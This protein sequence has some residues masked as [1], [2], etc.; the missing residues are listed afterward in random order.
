VEG[1]GLPAQEKNPAQA[2]H[3][4]GAASSGPELRGALTAMNSLASALQYVNIAAFGLLALVCLQKWRAQR[5]EAAFWAFATFGL[6]AIV[7]V[8]GEI[9]D[10]AGDPQ[11]WITKVLV[12]LIALFPYSLYR[13][14][15]SFSRP[16][17]WIELAAAGATAA[18]VVWSLALPDVPDQGEPRSASFAIFVIA[19]LVQWTALSLFVALRL[20]RAGQGQPTVVRHRMRLLAVGAIALS[21]V[22][23]LA[24][25][26]AA[27][28]SPTFEVVQGLL[29]LASMFLFF[30]GFA[31]PKALR[32]VWREPE[33][34]LLRRSVDELLVAAEPEDV[35][36]IVL[37]Q[38]AAIV[39]ARG[40]ALLD[41]D[42]RLL[43]AYGVDPHEAAERAG[44]ERFDLGQGAVVA[45]TSP[46]APL[47][48]QEEFELLR[49][50]GGFALLAYERKSQVA[51]E[52]K[53]LQE[54]DQ[55]K[56]NFI[57]LASHELRT[58]ASVI[59]GIAS[60][61]HLRGDLLEDDQI[62]HLRQTLYEQTDRMRRLVDQLLDLSR[63][64]ANGIRIEPQPLNVFS[65]VHELIGLVATEG[66]EEVTV[67]IPANLEALVDP[68]AFD[69]I[70]SNLIVNATRYGA[71][72]IEIS[73]E[74]RDR[75]FR[76]RVE[77]HGHGVPAEFVPQLFER[78]TRSTSAGATRTE[79][80]GLGLAI[81]KSYA[82]AHGGDLLY[83]DA[84]PHGARFELVLPRELNNH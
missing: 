40:V 5:G 67:S 50:L 51:R 29:T 21:I 57:A 55:L 35:T 65:R 75:H 38:M 77:D 36:R 8:T 68:N 6:L 20:W 33:E 64:E 13:F 30:F 83:E 69:R 41:A 32:K 31:P 72:P 22:L 82:Q 58:P 73:A 79:G 14:A 11:L 26:A 48:A 18:L 46:Y 10:A 49:G 45:W 47:F 53:A 80:A 66:A 61:L 78:F 37:P 44:G 63:L 34:E 76:L 4:R 15:A 39:G 25:L 16:A 2:L 3:F 81:A 60:T 52:R 19:L 54:A 42:D 74:Q 24:G 62:G 43:G 27:D 71:A 1:R 23:I 70:V 12:A 84:S 17:R 59:H 56:T 7:A 28:P 9:V